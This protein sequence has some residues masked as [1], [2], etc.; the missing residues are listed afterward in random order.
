MSFFKSNISI[1]IIINLLVE[2]LLNFRKISINDDKKRFFKGINYSKHN[3]KL[4]LNQTIKDAI[5]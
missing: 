4:Q 3:V 5:T 2:L 1:L